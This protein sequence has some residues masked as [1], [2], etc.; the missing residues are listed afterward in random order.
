MLGRGED[1]GDAKRRRFGDMDD[2]EGTEL[3]EVK[4]AQ[5]LA[6]GADTKGKADESNE[7][8][9]CVDKGLV[10]DEENEEDNCGNADW[11][12]KDSA[13]A[14]RDVGRVRDEDGSAND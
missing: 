12:D 11:V 14:F 9:G 6:R 10:D 4:G 1:K 7:G 13:D 2:E 3:L 5:E 8:N